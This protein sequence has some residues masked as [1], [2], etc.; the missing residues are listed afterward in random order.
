MTDPQPADHADEGVRSAHWLPY[1]VAAVKIVFILVVFRSMVGP[2][3]EDFFDEELLPMPTWEW[4]LCSV[5]P[6]ILIHLARRP[7]IWAQLAGE[8]MF[9]RIALT[10]YLLYALAFALGQG[11]WILWIAVAASVGGFGGMLYLDRRNPADVR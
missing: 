11:E 10:F 3:T 9:L 2:F 6:G 7:E 8:R 5:T 1:G 4:S